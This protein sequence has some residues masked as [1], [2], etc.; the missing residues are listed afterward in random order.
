MMSNP[1]GIIITF[2]S[3]DPPAKEGKK[4]V[5][6]ATADCKAP[7]FRRI[8]ADFNASNSAKRSPTQK[9][10]VRVTALLLQSVVASQTLK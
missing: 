3:G 2:P 6:R 7:A 1:L 9:C 8:L 5:S 4:T 10:F